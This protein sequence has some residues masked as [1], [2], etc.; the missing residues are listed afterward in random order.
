MTTLESTV[1][2]LAKDYLITGGENKE[3][4][5][6]RVQKQVEEELKG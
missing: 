3:I 6:G 5:F 2:D 4:S 1:E